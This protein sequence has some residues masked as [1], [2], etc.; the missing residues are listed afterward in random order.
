[1]LRAIRE[2]RTLHQ[3]L[4]EENKQWL[5]SKMKDA[6]DGIGFRII[7]TYRHVAKAG[8]T[9]AAWFDLGLPTVGERSLLTRRVGD[10]LRAEDVLV[11]RLP[12][13]R[14]LEKA[15]RPDDNEKPVGEIVEAFLKYPH[16]PML[17]SEKVVREAI[18]QGVRDGL[19][20]IRMGDEILFRV[21]LSADDLDD[22]AILVRAA[23]IQ[24][25]PP[26]EGGRAVA[27]GPEPT[28]VRETAASACS[29]SQ[30]SESGIRFYK[31]HAQV[32]WDKLTDVVRGVIGP[33]RN[34][35]A[36]L[37]VEVIVTARSPSG[38]I[39]ES[40]LNQK[41]RE[42]LSQIGAHFEEESDP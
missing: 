17:E 4:H 35:G 32:P 22:G 1:A 38:G 9:E 40:T 23:A 33:L 14:V 29:P 30:P 19:F 3:Q 18:V 28:A 10:F 31:V 11:S 34:D 26:P 6:E 7:S 25:V 13:R 20:G 42:T 27:A 2:D 5:M 24:A 39:R 12:P 8:G 16:L 41:V 36:E 21:A 37:E 15:L